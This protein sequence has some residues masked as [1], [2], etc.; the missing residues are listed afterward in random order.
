MAERMLG[1]IAVLSLVIWVGGCSS[2]SEN[3]DSGTPDGGVKSLC[4]SVA[5]E[6]ME[7][8][9]S[10]SKL[11]QGPGL[12]DI[13]GLKVSLQGNARIV[14]GREGEAVYLSGSGDGVRVK[15]FSFDGQHLTVEA[16]V[17]PEGEQVRWATVVDY[18]YQFKG[19]WLGG[20]DEAGGYEFWTGN[21]YAGDVDGLV[22]GKW[23]HLAGVY[24]GD[25]GTLSLF[26]NGIEMQ[27]LEGV[28]TYSKPVLSELGIGARGDLSDYFRGTIDEVMVWSRVRSAQEICADAG[29]SWDG[30][31]CSYSAPVGIPPGPCAGVDCSGHGSCLVEQ[32]RP[33]CRCDSGYH[34]DGFSCVQ[35]EDA[36]TG[37]DDAIASWVSWY[38]A[39]LEAGLEEKIQQDFIS[40][41][42]PANP[43]WNPLAETWTALAFTGL[44]HNAQ[45][46]F[47]LGVLRAVEN[48]PRNP[49][50]LANAAACMLLLGYGQ[51]GRQF[52]DCSYQLAPHNA[53]TAAAQAYH[54]YEFNGDIDAALEKF[55]EAIEKDPSNPEW[56]YQA[57]QLALK[58]NDIA[59]AN[60][61]LACLPPASAESPGGYRG[62]LPPASPSRS[63]VYCCPCD[64]PTA[65]PGVA[66]CIQDS[67]ASL[68]CFVGICAFTGQCQ[69]GSS[70]FSVQF[71]VCYPPTGLQICF[72]ADTNGNVGFEAG[73]S[74]FNGFLGAGVGLTYNLVNK[75]CNVVF[76]A[77]SGKLPINIGFSGTYDPVASKFEAAVGGTGKKGFAT[78]QYT[79][80]YF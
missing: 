34:A 58:K 21:D 63:G 80:L 69:E 60:R 66:E 40:Q 75:K 33:L 41:Y 44:L 37:I 72:I 4:P 57:L 62:T 23:Q 73:A 3:P 39:G 71:K 70:P 20:S 36:C 52:L 17:R 25:A 8:C 31:A 74:L 15:D 26:V 78:G 35:D 2:S 55:D 30:Q 6:G 24:N 54:E 9:L 77:G 16:W 5:P 48:D 42:Q 51:D 18:W 22:D 14:E 28:A 45:E 7:L 65:Y 13:G 27:R 61:Y 19:F 68:A 12:S 67:H 53:A 47:C 38:A 10:F 46:V 32:G 56:P 49:V 59:L 79:F 1:S 50:A 43:A 64:P 11:E 29:G 76:D